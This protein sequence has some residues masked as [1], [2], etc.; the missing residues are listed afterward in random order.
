MDLQQL[1]KELRYVITKDNFIGHLQKNPILVLPIRLSLG[2]SQRE[3]VRKTEI[4]QVT[5][6]KYEKR[7]SKFMSRRKAEVI[8]DLFFSIKPEIN[9]NKIIKLYKKFKDIQ[10]GKLMTSERA[11]VLQKIWQEKTTKKQR[12]EWGIKGA[13]ITNK[14]IRYTKQEKLLVDLFNKNRVDYKAHFDITT[15]KLKLNIDFVIF[16]HNKPSIIIEVTERR[17]NLYEYSLSYCYKAR[18]LKE[19]Y[20]WIK[21]IFIGSDDISESSKNLLK[22][23]FDYVLKMSEFPNI[24]HLIQ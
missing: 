16:K 4:S 12:S 7:K 14:K 17:G 21:L 9:Y 22:N 24:L 20:P 3:F 1:T 8:K 23:E 13:T 11:R 6:I 15:K 10:T 2:F 19:K 5:L 18:L